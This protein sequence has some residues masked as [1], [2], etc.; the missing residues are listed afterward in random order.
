MERYSE[1]TIDNHLQYQDVVIA[2]SWEAFSLIVK[3]MSQLPCGVVDDLC[4][5]CNITV[6]EDGGH[7][8]LGRGLAR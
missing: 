4:E 2:D 6:A 5:N 1:R 8:L 3:A 7:S